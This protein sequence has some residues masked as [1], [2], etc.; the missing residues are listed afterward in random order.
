MLN[1]NKVKSILDAEGE[2]LIAELQAA[3]VSTGAN[4]SGETSQSLASNVSM[5]DNSVSWEV[6]GGIGWQ[7]VEQGR[8]K[9]KAS[10][11][12]SLRGIIRQWIDDK[13][14]EPEDGISKDSL[15][16]LITRAIHRRGTLLHFLKE[17]R[18]I[19]SN[20][21]TDQYIENVSFKIGESL[22]EDVA[23]DLS[24]RIEKIFR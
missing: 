8:A 14:I 7:F 10:G 4:A 23:D 3:M 15:A 22:A 1:L 17:T 19:Y 21:I 6:Y 20:V 12:G 24:K 11:D 13:G 16:F 18:E 5:T 9:T 2:K